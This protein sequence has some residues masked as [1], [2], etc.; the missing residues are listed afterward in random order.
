[1]RAPTA[2][3]KRI[4]HSTAARLSTGSVP[5]SARST[6]HA[7]VFGGAP[8][9]V[10]APENALLRVSSCTC[11]SR[12]ITTSWP[13]TRAADLTSHPAGHRAVPVACLLQRVRHLQQPRLV[14]VLA[15]QLQPDRHAVVT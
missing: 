4:A 6:A 2:R 12:P 10:D 11:V 1:M 14:E 13:R 7:C 15:D 5:G 8:K 9:A 3:P